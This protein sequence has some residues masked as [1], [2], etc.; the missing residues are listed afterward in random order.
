MY[1]IAPAYSV[2]EGRLSA[3]SEDDWGAAV[4]AAR[5]AAVHEGRRD[6]GA[7]NLAGNRKGKG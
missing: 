4:P 3:E 2:K 5:N 1:R 6:T 7:T